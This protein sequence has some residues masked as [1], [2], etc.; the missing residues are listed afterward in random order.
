MRFIINK[1][2]LSYDQ[3]KGKYKRSESKYSRV[4]WSATELYKK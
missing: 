2:C 3:Q 4:A 1:P